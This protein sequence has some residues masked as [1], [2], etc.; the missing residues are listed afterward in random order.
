MSE[1]LI[2][3]GQG[4]FVAISGEWAGW[5]YHQLPGSKDVVRVCKGHRRDVR[6]VSPM[7]GLRRHIGKKDAQAKDRERAM[8]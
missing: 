7:E 5:V 8:A 2:Y 1:N 4:R 3:V 6:V